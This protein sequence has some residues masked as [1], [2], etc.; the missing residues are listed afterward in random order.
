MNAIKWNKDSVI[1]LDQRRLPLDEVYNTYRNYY[2]IVNSIKEMEIRGAPAIGI[3]A[4]M[5]IALAAK[6]IRENNINDFRAD[7]NEI[8]GLFASAR[9]TANNL[10]WAIKRMKKIINSV[11]D[12]NEMR[13]MLE[14]EAVKMYSEDIET[15]KKIGRNGSRFLSDGDIVMTHC[16]AGSLA[17]AGYGTALGVIRAAI[18]EGKKIEVFA[19]E[20]RPYLQGARLTAWELQ[21]D[22]IPVTLITDNMSGHFMKEGVIR[23]VIVGADRIASNG[24]TANKIGTYMHSVAAKTNNIPFYVAA[25]LSTIDTSLASGEGIDIEERS[26]DE[27][28]YIRSEQIAPEGISVRHPAFDVTPAEF[29]SAIITEKGVIEN[30]AG[31]GVKELF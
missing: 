8:C 2:D 30:P 17:T 15:N 1:I 21:K 13:K 31:K 28:V 6:S 14:N 19:C 26:I 23:K 27:V 18:E 20:T 9:P 5:G 16:N 29:I 10:F 11:K 12:I 4:A 3:A 24:D 7:M 25:P 22:K